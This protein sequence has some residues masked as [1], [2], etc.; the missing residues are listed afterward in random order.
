MEEI[1]TRLHL[2]RFDAVELSVNVIALALAFVIALPVGW[3]REKST[4]TMGLRTFPLVAAASAAFVMMARSAFEGAPDAQARVLQGVLTGIGFIGGGAILK[5][6][7]RVLGAATAAALW[8]TAGIGAAVAHGLYE[9]AVVL[10]LVS[11]L[12]LRVMGPVK[13]QMNGNEQWD[14]GVPGPGE[15]DAEEEEEEED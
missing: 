7:E 10:S 8:G 1:I 15:G 3:D 12:T 11:F 6:R 4:R 14:D 13:K 2:H 9:V 5:R